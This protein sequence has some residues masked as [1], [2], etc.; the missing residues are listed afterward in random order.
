MSTGAC[1]D[2][3]SD[4]CMDRL[5]RMALINRIYESL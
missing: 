3:D 2:E 4:T 1:E 5:A